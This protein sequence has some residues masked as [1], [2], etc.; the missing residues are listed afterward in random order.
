MRTIIFLAGLPGCGKSTWVKT[1]RKKHKSFLVVNKDALRFMLFDKAWDAK[2]EKYIAPIAIWA[3][4]ELTHGGKNIIIDE[5]CCR[6]SI[7]HSYR[8][9][10][11]MSG[12]KYRTICIYFKI[13]KRECYKRDLLRDKRV[14]T[15]VIDKIAGIFEPPRKS[16]KFDKI[17]VVT[18]KH[19]PEDI[20]IL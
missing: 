1:F 3:I 12:K 14:G 5:T 2:L 17:I 16:E 10:I 13:D 6:K 18:K 8:L 11:E 20:T 15:Q 19:K 7:R 4:E 9:A